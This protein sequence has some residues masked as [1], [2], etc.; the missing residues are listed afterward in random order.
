MINKKDLN[1]NIV[2]REGNSVLKDTEDIGFLIFNMPARISC[3]YSTK[4]CRKSCYAVSAENLF[5][6]SVLKRRMIHMEE[7]K[8]DTFEEDMINL[9]EYHMQRKKYKGKKIYF[10]WHESGDIYSQD[11]FIKMI[12][13]SN[14]F[15]GIEDKISFQAYTKSLPIIS[16]FDLEKV[17]IKILFSIVEDTKQEDID[18]ATSLSLGMFSA[19]EDPDI[20]EEGFKCLGDCSKCQTCY[21]KNDIKLTFVENHGSRVKRKKSGESTRIEGSTIRY[22]RCYSK[23]NN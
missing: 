12:N 5:K 7:T 18:I 2:L 3:P 19:V 11:Y 16:K 4:W 21:E 14:H 1:K 13:I 9:I 20:Y 15:K 17:N 10:R 8:K 6:N 23:N 22:L